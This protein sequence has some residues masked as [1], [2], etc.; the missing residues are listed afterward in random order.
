LGSYAD[1]LSFAL[2]FIY[3]MD[4]AEV[5]F[6]F[7]YRMVFQ[8]ITNARYRNMGVLSEDEIID[9]I[10]R[11][12]NVLAGIS[13]RE[14]ELALIRNQRA[15][16]RFMEE[17]AQRADVTTTASG[18]QYRVIRAGDG[19]RVRF[20]SNVTVHYTGRFIDGELFDSSHNR[21]EPASFN[22]DDVIAGWSE[23]L[24]LM[25]AGDVFEFVIPDSLAYGRRGFDIIEPGAHLVFEVE[26]I[27]I[28][29]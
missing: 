8:G 26:V 6:E 1:S 20:D 19:R 29:N 10:G 16:H 14:D 25:R 7:N 28:D 18:L 13:E 24:Q 22:V 11:F 3:G 21:G 15:G 23:G 17:N 4:I 27:S 9:L 2:G 5:P 12:H